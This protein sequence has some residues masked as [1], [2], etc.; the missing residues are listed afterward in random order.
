MFVYF[1]MS[2]PHTEPHYIGPLGGL[3]KGLL[4]FWTYTKAFGKD[5]KRFKTSVFSFSKLA[6][7]Q[8]GDAALYL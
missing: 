7:E 2:G 3:R 6:R 5:P 8:I 4:G 1:A